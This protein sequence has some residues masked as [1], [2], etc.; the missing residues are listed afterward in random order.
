MSIE[1]VQEPNDILSR[2]WLRVGDL[3]ARSRGAN[4]WVGTEELRRWNQNNTEPCGRCLTSKDKT[5]C[6]IAD[7]HPS[8]LTCRTKKLSCDRRAR[9]VFEHTRDEFFADFQDFKVAFSVDPPKD[10]KAIN[11]T[12]SKNR[13]LALEALTGRNGKHAPAAVVLGILH[14]R[15]SYT[16]V[17]TRIPEEIQD[18][19]RQLASARTQIVSLRCQVEDRLASLGEPEVFLEQLLHC[20]DYYSLAL[21]DYNRY[22]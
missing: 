21:T 20:T 12:K 3:C 6:D 1:Q 14:K 15:R 9:F 19:S 7:D 22:L 10:I 13:R 4:G 16:H 8:C 11:R 2:F 5:T 18:L 17:H